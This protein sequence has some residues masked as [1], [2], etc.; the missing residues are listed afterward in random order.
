MPRVRLIATGGTIATVSHRNTTSA[1]LSASE[2]LEQAQP[3]PP[4]I[5]VDIED[6]SR[7]P[8]WSLDAR[9]MHQIALRARAAATEPGNSGVVV[10]HGTS[11]IEYT[12]FLTDL[13]LP[14]EAPV[15]FTGA[16][17]TADDHDSDGPRNLRDAL[18]VAA[19]ADARSM[20]AVVCFSGAIFPARYAQKVQRQAIDAFT[21]PVAG[22]IDHRGVVVGHPAWRPRVFEGTIEPEVSLVKAYPGAGRAQIDAALKEGSLGIVIEGLPGSGG[23]PTKMSQG[24]RAAVDAGVPVV[25]SSRA[26]YGCVPSSPTG[27]TGDPLRD[28]DLISSGDL[29]PE[30][31]WVLLAVALGEAH[32]DRDGVRKIFQEVAQSEVRVTGRA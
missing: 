28:L 22:A 30:K 18:A 10:T 2:L 1:R 26:P 29:T 15:A 20:G 19:A 31:S 24:V 16:M 11:T 3:L 6:F 25:L 4:D 7:V 23:I 27:G 14:G 12:A 32:H 21:G 5:E 9:S 13:L 8:S 17:R